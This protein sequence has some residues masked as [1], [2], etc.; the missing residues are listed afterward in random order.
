MGPE[1]GKRWRVTIPQ[2]RAAA[3]FDPKT[4]VPTI[5]TIDFED[6]QTH[7]FV[8]DYGHPIFVLAPVGW[9]GSDILAELL[10]EYQRVKLT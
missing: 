1:H 6:Y 7:Q 9:T 8:S 5:V 10:F 4:P 3:D 2:E